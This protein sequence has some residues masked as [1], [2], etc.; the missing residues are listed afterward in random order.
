MK[1]KI[2]RILYYALNAHCFIE[3]TIAYYNNIFLCM[4]PLKIY[5]KYVIVGF[6][7]VRTKIYNSEQ[8]Y[9]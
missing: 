8:Y 1:N 7:K 4:I 6:Y 2:G 3:P 9:C 5:G